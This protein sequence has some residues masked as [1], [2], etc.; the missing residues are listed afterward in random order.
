MPLGA[1]IDPPKL[2]R[3]EIRGALGTGGAGLVL[4]A[5]DR[6]THRM[7][8]L[9]VPRNEADHRQIEAEAR[10]TAQLEHPAIVPLYDAAEAAD[11]TPYYT[12]R[13][14][15]RRSL[16]DV[17]REERASWTLAR[18]VSILVQV[19][20]ALAYAH[21]RGVVHRDLKPGNVLVGDFGE[22][23]LADWGIARI[24]AE[25]PV[26]PKRPSRPADEQRRSD[27]PAPR[28]PVAPDVTGVVGTPGYMAPELLRGEETDHRV[29]LFALGVILYEV[30]AGKAPFKR[31]TTAETLVATFSDEPVRPSSTDPSCPL[32]LEDLCLALLAKKPEARAASAD[33][34]AARLEEFLEGAREKER[35]SAEARKLCELADMPVRRWRELD[36][37]RS[38]LARA[39]QELLRRVKPWEPPQAKQPAWDLE[40]RADRAERDQGV[41]LAE[42]IELYTKALGYDAACEDAHR[43]LA[44]LYFAQARVAEATRSRGA[45]VYYETLVRE[46]DDGRYAALLGAQAALTLVTKPIDAHVVAR[47]YEEKSRVLVLGEAIDLGETPLRGARLPAGSW[48]LELRAEGHRDTRLPVM[49]A[50]GGHHDATVHLHTDAEIG[51][52]FLYVPAGSVQLGDDPESYDGLRS[53]EIVVPDFAIGLQPITFGEYCAFLDDLHARDPELA[54]R[55]EPHGMRG[56]ESAIV[57]RGPRGYR[58]L[59]QLIEGDAAKHFP[60]AD[61]HFANVPVMFVSW[62]DARAYC[63]WRNEREGLP[64]GTIRLP[65]EA[66]WEKAARGADRRFYPWGDRFDPTFCHMKDS[67]SYM[68]QPEP[69]L[70]FPRDESPYGIRDLA[71][72]AREWAA[73]DHGVAMARDLEAEP[74]PDASLRW[75]ESPRR[76]ARGGNFFTDHKW[77]RAASRSPL[78]ALVRAEGVSFRLA[79]TLRSG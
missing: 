13:I 61:G 57:E 75:D 34:V 10:V 63:R 69:V 51:E 62:Y 52:G 41:A 49:L 29:D 15:G 35:R 20:R 50:R 7:V 48:L 42:A 25:S 45:Q 72:G 8:A 37:D 76:R 79:K 64:P 53:Q 6:E 18:L 4:A 17:L 54:K 22:V 58:P 73:D 23:Y 33:V 9:K 46:H 11:G 39:A 32:L 78:H 38:G 27:A 55:R 68:T 26:Q 28:A 24:G 47:R 70:G 1:G 71:G 77:C 21:V 60:E 31:E 5:L 19:A 44:A 16:R 43:G 14:V 59:P 40:D 56:A 30:L 65:T 74:E 66:E 67:R 36:A 3:Y 12:M 2:E